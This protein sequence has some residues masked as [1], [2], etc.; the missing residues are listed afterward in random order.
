MKMKLIVPLLISMCVSV[1]V[2]AATSNYVQTKDIILPDYGAS[3]PIKGETR[4][5]TITGSTTTRESD[6]MELGGAAAGMIVYSRFTP[7]NT[8]GEYLLVHGTNSFSCFVY[9]KSDHTIVADLRRDSTNRIGELS[10][11]RWDYSGNRPTTVYFVYGMKFYSM[12]ILTSNG[13][14]TLI[15][16]FSSD[17]PG[18]AMIQNSVEGDSSS[19]SRYWSWMVLS[20][21]YGSTVLEIFTYDKLS[22]TILG[23]LAPADLVGYS[24]SIPKPNMVEISPLGNK[25]V[26]HYGKCWGSTPTIPGPWT[27][28]GNGV[29]SAPYKAY[30]AGNNSFNWVKNLSVTLTKTVQG[31]G[32]ALS[33][34]ADNQWASNSTSDKL[35]IRLVGGQTPTS[36]SATLSYGVR[37]ED[38]TNNPAICKPHAWDLDFTEPINVSVDETHSGWAFD[39]AGR[40]L[41]ISQNNTTDWIEARDILTGSAISILYHGDIGWSCGMHFGKLYDQSQRGWF[42]LSTTGDGATWG[43]KQIIMVEVKDKNIS[44]PRI[45]RVSP[46]YNMSSGYRGESSTAF[47]FDGKSIY[48]TTGWG[49]DA[50]GDAYSIELPSSWPILSNDAPPVWATA[51][52]TN[53]SGKPITVSGGIKIR[54]Q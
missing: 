49:E 9:R 11:I 8:T 15:R 17:F 13:S 19:D 54:G 1:N 29:F 28:E 14:P 50:Y 26:T 4:L 6:V 24:T 45:W 48:W 22:N 32:S 39:E 18:G 27:D 31:T 21:M 35:F 44:T 33:I 47:G 52:M 38:N 2:F 5:N 51:I 43:S 37:P 53:A 10:E 25:V 12:D 23:R 34:S 36:T 42:L 41:F 7:T 30:T 3:I 46:T 20:T 40:E 16:D